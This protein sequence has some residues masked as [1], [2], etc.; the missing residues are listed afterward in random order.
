[1]RCGNEKD[2]YTFFTKAVDISP[3]MAYQV[4]MAMK[5]FPGV[6]CIVAPYEADAQLAFFARNHLIDAVITEDSD[7]LA[8]GS[9]RVL[10]KLDAEGNAD[11]VLTSII[12]WNTI[13][14]AG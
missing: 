9:P 2:A 13:I 10:F 1:M 7:I 11:E 8:Y 12:I 14:L 6:E 3:A 5:E 4:I